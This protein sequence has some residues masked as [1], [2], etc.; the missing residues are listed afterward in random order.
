MATDPPLKSSPDLPRAQ[1]TP[2][3]PRSTMPQSIMRQS[4]M[5]QW[6]ACEIRQF[7]FC[8]VLRDDELDHLGLTVETVSRTLSRLK[9]AGD[10][11]ITDAHHI[12][13]VR[14]ESLGD[15]AEGF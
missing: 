4:I 6:A 12:T 11:A 2:P 14:P 15:I 3:A 1:R 13:I 9:R 5:P 10:I 8:S 7:T